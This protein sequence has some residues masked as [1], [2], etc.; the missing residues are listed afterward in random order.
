[1]GAAGEGGQS[2]RVWRCGS[3]GGWLGVGRRGG[4]LALVVGSVSLW[5]RLLAP[6]P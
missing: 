3:P 1:M 4:G 2:P 6:R 5:Q